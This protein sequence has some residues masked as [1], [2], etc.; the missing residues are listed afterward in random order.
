MEEITVYILKDMDLK[1]ATVIN[2]FP[3]AGL[4]SAITANY[5]IGTLKLDQIAFLDSLEFPPVSMIYDNKPKFPARIYGD[6]KAKLVIFLS[7]FTPLINL[8]RPLADT[9]FDFVDKNQCS[10][11]IA[12]EAMPARG[13]T[14]EVFGVGST[15]SARAKISELGI[16]PISYGVIT[17]IPGVMLN[18]GRKRDFDVRSP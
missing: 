1:G 11:I 3:T 10:N 17:G 14:L 16:K 15:D 2:G 4:V 18:E 7:E 5:L 6:E 8:I 9:V 13:E 12:P